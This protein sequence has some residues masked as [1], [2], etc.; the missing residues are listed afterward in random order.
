M[1]MGD[2]LNDLIAGRRP[3]ADYDGAVKDYLDN[4]GEQI[5][6]EYLQALAA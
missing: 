5:R 1:A 3:M 6:R 4:G 2:A